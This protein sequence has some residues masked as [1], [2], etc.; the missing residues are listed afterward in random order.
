MRKFK[1]YAIGSLNP[2]V[3]RIGF[4]RVVFREGFSEAFSDWRRGFSDCIKDYLPLN[5]AVGL[6]LNRPD[7]SFCFP[8]NPVV[9]G[10][11]Y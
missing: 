1:E 4:F 5:G 11:S 8:P 2:F 3:S 9:I 10:A 6:A 7:S